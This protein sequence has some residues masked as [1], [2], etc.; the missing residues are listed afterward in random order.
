MADSV[1]NCKKCNKIF[2]RRLGDVCPHC[3]K[4]EEEHFTV[5]YRTLQKTAAQGGIS[6]EA[7]AKQVG[8][9]AETIEKMY[10]EG[11]LSTAG[12]YLKLPCQQC[13]TLTQ[14]S[15]RKGRYCLRCSES[16]ATQAGVEVKS[17]QEIRKEE[18]LQKRQ[19][20]QMELLKKPTPPRKEAEPSRFGFTVRHL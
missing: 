11:R 6:L 14:E 15:G 1:L 5:L 3:I 19:Q 18:D 2:Q 4:Q 12:V 10:L 20:E 13:G 8:I 9:P 7:L 17:I 16:T